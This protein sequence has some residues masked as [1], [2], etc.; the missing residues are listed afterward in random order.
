MVGSQGK[1]GEITP[2]ISISGKELP[3]TDDPDVLPPVA[4]DDQLTT[5]EP[6]D[7]GREESRQSEATPE[8]S[9]KSSR[10]PTPIARSEVE[11]IQPEPVR[12][13]RK[14][15]AA[16]H[17]KGWNIWTLMLLL[18]TL[19]F[20]FIPV[21][22]LRVPVNGL[23][24]MSVNTANIDKNTNTLNENI[25]KWLDLSPCHP[26]QFGIVKEKVLF[27]GRGKTWKS[28]I[29]QCSKQ[30]HASLPLIETK[31]ELDNL[32][33]LLDDKGYDGWMVSLELDSMNGDKLVYSPG[34][35]E[36]NFLNKTQMESMLSEVS[37]TFLIKRIDGTTQR[38][39]KVLENSPTEASRTC[40]TLGGSLLKIYNEQDRQL[41]T[42]QMFA[43]GENKILIALRY[44]EHTESLIWPDGDV[45]YHTLLDATI[46]GHESEYEGMVLLETPEDNQTLQKAVIESGGFPF[47]CT[48][49]DV[50]E[51]NFFAFNFKP[52]QDLR[53]E[54]ISEIL[55]LPLNT[56]VL[57]QKEKTA[58]D[59]E[60][61]RLSHEVKNEIDKLLSLDP[62]IEL[63]RNMLSM[64]W[65]T[66]NMST[67]DVCWPL[68]A[69]PIS[70]VNFQEP[71]CF[72]SEEDLRQNRV[73]FQTFSAQVRQFH[74]HMLATKTFMDYSWDVKVE[75]LFYG[76]VFAYLKQIGA[77]FRSY[78]IVANLTCSFSLIIT[79]LIF[80]SKRCFCRKD[81]RRNC[82][83]TLRKVYNWCCETNPR[84]D[85]E[86]STASTPKAREGPSTFYPPAGY[87]LV[88]IQPPTSDT[89][90]AVVPLPRSQRPLIP[91]DSF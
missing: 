76:N 89:P 16:G 23:C 66:K 55:P 21:N 79:L 18:N 22:A 61:K 25:A 69:V 91:I 90:Y 52:N 75:V 14:R 65:E 63:L 44:D 49:T 2:I 36:L 27:Q 72:K 38:W 4:Q 54:I 53:L 10:M 62:P 1:G 81:R 50:F 34:R 85:E 41:I 46:K 24:P 17:F 30:Y 12:G 7:T 45:Y 28:A 74:Q 71:F 77:N 5:D 42:K 73:N 40:H 3:P 70:V 29:D 19:F 43:L 32:R 39:V 68:E 13:K 56:A 67:S 11:D 88:E 59:D 6:D 84:K 8:L 26:R 35:Q 87:Q 15:P 37:P 57:C 9:Q 51:T 47:F 78:L 48:F 83:P 86:Q 33:Y 82:V 31:E 80:C 20:F 60:A 58:I 64:E